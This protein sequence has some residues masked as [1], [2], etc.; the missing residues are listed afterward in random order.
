MGLFE[1]GTGTL[2]ALTT[3]VG[4]K[5]DPR[6]AGAPLTIYA[7]GVRNAFDLVW[8]SNGSLY[9]PAN[10]SAAGG[11]TPAGKGAPA[12]TGV[13]T[14]ETDYLFRITRGGHFGHPNPAHDKFVLNGGNPT[15]G[16]DPFEV[17]DYPVGTKPDAAWKQAAFDFGAHQSPN[18][19]IEFRGSQF[20][21]ALDGKLFVA[22]T[23][24]AATTSAP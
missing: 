11:N 21:G 14:A 9:A 22:R 5:Y 13:S 8:H 6:A 4:G 17:I 23:A 12:L 1:Y 18:G 19:V 2:D 15:A 3:G 20:G 10:G 24:A 16:V 7:D